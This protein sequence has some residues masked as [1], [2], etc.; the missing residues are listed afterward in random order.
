MTL[1]K[2]YVMF[3]SSR[4]FTAVAVPSIEKQKIFHSPIFFG[5]L[6]RVGI[7]EKKKS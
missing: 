2:S 4:V 1:L 6:S 7:S 5:D 3:I